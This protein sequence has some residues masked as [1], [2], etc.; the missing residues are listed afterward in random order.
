MIIQRKCKMILL[1]AVLI[2]VSLAGC[3]S[4]VDSESRENVT[5]DLD[6]KDIKIDEDT[7]IRFVDNV[8]LVYFK[9]DVDD[10]IKENLIQSINGTVIGFYPSMD[11][12]QIEIK[13]TDL[14]TLKK[15]SQQLM[16]HDAVMLAS[17]DMV[18]KISENSNDAY[19]VKKGKQM[20]KLIKTDGGEMLLN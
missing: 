3:K 12:Y 10:E 8:L 14:K 5:Y 1:I 15:I 7:G 20:M 4:K 2:V 17:Y 18:N 9:P 6:E 16:E 19:S 13:E 11:Y